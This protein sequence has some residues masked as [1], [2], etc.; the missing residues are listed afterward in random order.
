[1]LALTVHKIEYEGNGETKVFE[2]PFSVIKGSDIRVSVCDSYGRKN[3]LQSGYSVDTV[4][5]TVTYPYG[6][7][8][9][10]PLAVGQKLI[11]ERVTPLTQEVDLGNRWPFNVIEQALDK[12]TMIAQET[13]V[14]GEI[15]GTVEE[16]AQ[17]NIIEGIQINGIDM[18]IVNKRVN[19]LTI[20]LETINDL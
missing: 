18:P 9:L 20:P 16:G 5:K 3:V 1:M 7:D 13:A 12:V 2:Y 8:E 19:L 14:N 10:L 17:K 11:I 6:N 15:L 4:N